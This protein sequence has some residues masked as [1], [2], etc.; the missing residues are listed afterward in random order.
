MKRV[1]W[2][3]LLVVL[4]LLTA[5]VVY[6]ANAVAKTPDIA[7]SVSDETML[8]ASLL[9][10]HGCM[11]QPFSFSA[12]NVSFSQIKDEQLLI[13]RKFILQNKEI[14]ISKCT[15]PDENFRCMLVERHA[16]GFYIYC[17]RQIIV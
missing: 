8:S 15:P 7:V 9:N 2:Q 14:F 1:I 4:F 11:E 10:I 16:K 17:L 13:L 6:S 5:G 12:R 3:G